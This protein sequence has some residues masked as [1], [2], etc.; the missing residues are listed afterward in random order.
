LSNFLE[1]GLVNLK[2]IRITIGLLII[3]AAIMILLIVRCFYLQFFRCDYYRDVSSRQMQKLIRQQPYRGVI[4]DRRGRILAAS[5]KVQT[6]FAEPRMI[7]NPEQTSI[8]LASVL[9]VESQDILRIITESNNPGFVK[10]KADANNLECGMAKK[11]PAIGIETY[12]RRYYP[13][14]NLTSHL[15]GF[16]SSDN[17]GLEG[18]ELKYD[19]ILKGDM[20]EKVFYSDAPPYR[21][22]I[23][24]KENLEH[25][26]DGN[27]IILTIDAA[28]QQ[29]TRE[30]LEAQC[31][32]YQ[33]EA[34]VAIVAVPK[35]GEI[36]AMVSLPDFD[37]MKIVKVDDTFRNR[38][39][40]DQFEPG[41]I[42]K[43]MA[44]ALALDEGT[45]KYNDV[46]YCENGYY[47]GKGFGT[48]QEYS[49]H[50]Y[51]NLSI[52]DILV[53][54]SNIGMAKIGQKMSRNKLYNGL[55]QF[56]F[57]LK[58]DI[59]LPGEIAGV[60]RPPSVWTGYSVT[61][62]PFGQEITAT[63]MQMLKAYCIIANGGYQIKPY[64][65]KSIIN[66]E[67]KITKTYLPQVSD[68][69]IV[70]PNITKWIVRK[71]LVGVV[72]EGTGQKAKLKKW[73]VFGKTGTANI[74]N[75]D[76]KGYSDSDYIASFVGG[77][78]A[79]DPEIMVLVS[80]RKPNKKLGK[81]YTGGAVASPVVKEILEKTLTY[82][83]KY[84]L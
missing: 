39:I 41:S 19:K 47:H 46:I 84:P 2:S 55:R 30:S 26:E 74:A 40:T 64:V 42:M 32:A 81:G 67:G 79:E 58:T 71:A 73:Q 83:E 38:S 36:L 51:G 61:R 12:W 8:K 57:G 7:K 10:I 14:A 34:G 77:A 18:A 37:P 80:I 78:P 15:V 11:I 60:L 22:P 50:K 45:I 6:I 5:N 1:S 48:I 17:L 53:K 62:I 27:S 70:D 66:S 23:R 65:V 69:P 31:K 20:G 3:F 76:R 68:K 33:A 35:T 63:A 25:V 16:I 13:M 56:G 43:P 52:K 4:L 24:L 9:N 44:V 72:E 82:L 21:R 49:S 28:I 54:S 59:E 75:A 29:F